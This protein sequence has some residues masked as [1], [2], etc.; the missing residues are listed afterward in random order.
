[1]RGP[2]TRG[3]VGDSRNA[4]CNVP[5]ARLRESQTLLLNRPL[6]PAWT[7]RPWEVQVAPSKGDGR[8]PG[9]D[10]STECSS[11]PTTGLARPGPS[12]PACA[13][14]RAGFHLSCIY[15]RYIQAHRLS[16]VQVSADYSSG[17]CE[18]DFVVVVTARGPRD[19]FPEQNRSLCAVKFLI[20]GARQS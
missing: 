11:A 8:A 6:S 14:A 4:T 19:F 1:M 10:R 16:R 2:T 9:K 18:S 15:V 20:T 7:G 13:R 17:S 5:R 3:H 12:L